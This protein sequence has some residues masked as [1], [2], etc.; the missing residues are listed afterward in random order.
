MK[1]IITTL[2][3]AALALLG[4]APRAEAGTHHSSRVYISGY[5]SC[6]TPI[7]TERY[8]IGYDRCGNPIWGTRVV[9]RYYRPVVRQYHPVP[10][11]APVRYGR[12][13]RAGGGVIQGSFYR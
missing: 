12:G 5:R 9:P 6:G 11:P 4:A 7:Y 10:C 8:F 2:A 3:I 1:T 13:Y